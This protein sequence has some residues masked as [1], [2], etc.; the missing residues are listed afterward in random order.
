M[1][2]KIRL[3]LQFTLIVVV[4][5]LF[6]SLLVYYFLYS[7]QLS[8][9]RENLLEK[10]T[11]TATLFINVAEVDS[12][13]LMKIHESTASWAEEELVITDSAF[14]IVYNYKSNYLADRGVLIYN[15][16]N[17]LNY[18]SKSG[19]DGVFYSHIF[20]NK[21]YY[22]YILA[23]DLSRVE[24][25]RE[26]RRVLFWSILF[27]IC[28]SVLFSYFFARRA[29]R[30]ISD[31][32]RTTKEIN[33]LKLN[34]RLD[35]GNKKDEIAQLAVTFNGM[36]SDLELAFKNQQDFVSN[37]S[38]EL[39]TPLSVMIG[40]TDYF[41]NHKRTPEEYNNHLTGLVN[42]LKN[43][44]SLINSLL[45]L[46]QMNGSV[47]TPLADVR[48]DEIVFDAIPQVK[49]KY[50]DRRIIPRINYPDS[51][52]ELIIKGNDRLLEIALTNIID[53][54]CKF[55]DK[56]VIIE[57]FITP[58]NITVAITD[59]GIGI[60][61]DEIGSISNPF[62]RASNVKFIGGYGIGLSLVSRIL[63]IHEAKLNIQTS[64]NKGTS[65]ELTFKRILK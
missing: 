5:L 3:A 53:N 48:I 49:D 13:L 31:I 20:N 21:T 10:A 22:V 24:N 39:R 32:I 46:A 62:K 59:E 25:L 4:I 30:P 51:G 50:P 63:E 27:S 16:S 8:K 41:L 29:I 34:Q 26:L 40:E 42:D 33:S 47:T 38:H 2:I 52:S 15:H 60:P 43:L 37:A 23:A 6:F 64:I 44:N 7:S 54:A 61:E 35:E 17:N 45:E 56:D 11:N 19:K 28:L 14:N 18:F 55:S 12:S 58:E 57:F 36:L 65:F 9:F 1:K